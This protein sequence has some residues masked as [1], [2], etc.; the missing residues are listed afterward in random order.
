MGGRGEFNV[1]LINFESA[2]FNLCNL[3]VSLMFDLT[4]S[5][6]HSASFSPARGHLRLETNKF[7][8]ALNSFFANRSLSLFIWTTTRSVVVVVCTYT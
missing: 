5:V 6:S 7:V 8:G 3:S 2:T 1:S 4:V